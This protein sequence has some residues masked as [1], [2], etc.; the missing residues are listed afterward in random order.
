MQGRALLVPATAL[1]LGLVFYGACGGKA[2]VDGEPAQGGGGQGGATSSNAVVGTTTTTTTTTTNSTQD[3]G[4][5]GSS[6]CGSCLDYINGD[7]QDPDELCRHSKQLWEVLFE[8][9]CQG[10]CAMQCIDNACNGD[11]AS[12]E[13]TGCVTSACLDEYMACTAD[14]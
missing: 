5:G 8:C 6:M 14:T 3:T 10:P 12:T 4:V 7:V 11:E 2:I 13:C 9:V 1:A